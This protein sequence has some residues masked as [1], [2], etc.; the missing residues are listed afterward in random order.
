MTRI[1][2]DKLRK[3]RSS[4]IYLRIPRSSAINPLSYAEGGCRLAKYDE[5]FDAKKPRNSAAG[6]SGKFRAA[7]SPSRYFLS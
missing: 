5:K 2:A 7:R 6:T 4:A 3:Q 1:F